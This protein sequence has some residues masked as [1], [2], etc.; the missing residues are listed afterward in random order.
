M[1][2]KDFIFENMKYDIF[3]Y[4]CI[5]VCT[6]IKSEYKNQPFFSMCS[7][8]FQRIWLKEEYIV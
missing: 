8:A 3:S 5:V 6:L 7:I 1:N 2:T 4:L